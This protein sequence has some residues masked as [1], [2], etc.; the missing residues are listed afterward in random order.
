MEIIPASIPLAV[1]REIFEVT[2]RPQ[3]SWGES[4]YGTFV[5]SDS[6]HPLLMKAVSE[7]LEGEYKKATI[8]CTMPGHGVH[9]HTDRVRPP[10]YS[11][12][13]LPIYTEGTTF[14]EDDVAYFMEEG[15]WRGPVRYWL[16]HSV[17]PN[18]TVRVHLIVD[19]QADLTTSGS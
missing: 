11:R 19:T 3:L 4:H 6:L 7:D 14:I 8:T 17:L 18:E 9:T 2:Y 5:T 12:W 13:H 15:Y 1:V 16:P 10:Y